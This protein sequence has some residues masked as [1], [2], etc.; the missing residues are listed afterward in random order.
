[1]RMLRTFVTSISIV[2]TLFSPTLAD[3]QNATADIIL[4]AAERSTAKWNDIGDFLD[5][6]MTAHMASHRIAGAALVITEADSIVYAK[7][8]GFSDVEDSLPVDPYATIF[9]TGS[10]GKLITWTAVMQ[11]VEQGRLDLDMDVNT[12]LREFSIP[13]TFPEPITMAHLMAHTPGFEERIIDIIV[14]N[15]DNLIDLG[16]FLATNMPERVR[17]P[18]EISGYSNYGAGLAGHIVAEISGMRYEDYVEKHIFEPLGMHHSTFRQPLPD[19]LKESM[20]G[21][22][23]FSKGWYEKEDFELFNGL[24]P[25]GTMSSTVSDMARFA[26]V[27]LQGGQGING[28]I[29][30]PESVTLMHQQLDANHP[31]VCGNAHGFWERQIKGVHILEHGGDTLFFHGL[32]ALIPEEKIGVYVCYNS[33]GKGSMPRVDLLEALINRLDLGG[34]PESLSEA[35]FTDDDLERFEGSF[36]STRAIETTFLK[37]TELGSTTTVSA[38]KNG[39][40]STGTRQWERTGELTFAEL[41]GQDHLVFVEDD[42]GGITHFLRRNVPEWAYLR[43]SWYE[44]PIFNG[45]AF[46]FCVMLFL[47]AALWPISV[48]KNYVVSRFRKQPQPIDP[49]RLTIGI[50]CW[51]C[52]LFLV[53]LGSLFADIEVILYGDSALLHSVLAFPMVT[54]VLTMACIVF[55]LRSRRRQRGSRRRLIHPALVVTAATFFHALLW[56]WNLLGP[57]VWG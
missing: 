31:D 45:V 42:N 52:L 27:H 28:R 20:S 44:S 23:S 5:G 47:S 1:M 57:N 7:G 32:L 13:A 56:Y 3:C 19:S 49:T 34:S 4:P 15:S 29:L 50:L 54:S 14:R 39:R 9:R 55:V 38:T 37:I 40:L 36:R 30:K 46:G 2:F 11:L 8:F 43:L 33:H 48:L 17:P 25:A 41:G 21:G 10:T 6:V 53:G 18:G 16:P 26:M 12:Y 35:E 22:Y 51:T 24:T